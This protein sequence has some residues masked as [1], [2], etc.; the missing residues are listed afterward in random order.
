MQKRVKYR[1]DADRYCI[2]ANFEKRGFSR[3]YSDDWNVYWASV[4]TVRSIFNPE[5]GRRLQDHQLINHFPTHSELTRKDL[6]AKNIKRY[7]RELER[8]AST[9]AVTDADGDSALDFLPPTFLLPADY[10]LVAEEFRK[11]PGAVWICKPTSRAQGKGIF[12]VTKLSQ[13]KRFAPPSRVREPYVVSLYVH[14]P[15]LVGGRKFDLRVY[16]LVRSFRPLKAYIHEEGFARFCAVRYSHAP[17]D[18]GNHFMHLTNVAIQKHG[19][20]YDARHGGKWRLCDLRLWVAGMYGQPAADAMFD[21]MEQAIL[22]SLRAVQGV[23][24][25]DPHCF[26]LYGFD[27]LIDAALKPWL[28]EVNASPSLS[29]STVEDRVMK[30]RVLHDTFSIVIPP[31]LSSRGRPAAAG[32]GSARAGRESYP[33]FLGNDEELGGFSVLVDEAAISAAASGEKKPATASARP[34]SARPR[35]WR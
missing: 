3:V 16:V 8:E 28:I 5:S 27:L 24:L 7:R 12:I 2:T 15:L 26:E 19:D 25:A 17:A 31:D 29:A 32:L 22:L 4:G 18:L 14:R 35:G 11:R 21:R 34:R 33:Q 6:M 13:L 10:A 9:L 1:L 23:M 30:T 20:D